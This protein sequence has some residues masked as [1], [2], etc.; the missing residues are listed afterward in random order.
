MFSSNRF[1]LIWP[2]L[3]EALHWAPYWVKLSTYLQN[4]IF[5]TDSGIE[6]VWAKYLFRL[7]V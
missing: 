2:N 1:R 5:A 7:V 6:T 4:R 3:G